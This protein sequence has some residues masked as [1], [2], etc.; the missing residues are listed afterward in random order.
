MKEH[1]ELDQAF[2]DF[3][4]VKDDYKGRTDY[5]CQAYQKDEFIRDPTA[6]VDDFES[7]FKR[8]YR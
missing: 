4:P 1:H 6:I 8:E 2:Q 7:K 3:D 5:L